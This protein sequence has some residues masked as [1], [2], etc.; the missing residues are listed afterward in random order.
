M[1][2]PPW[3][4]DDAG[5]HLVATVVL[6]EG[7]TGAFD[8]LVPETC[9]E[10]IQAGRRVRVPFGR[11]NRNVVGYCVEVETKTIGSRRLKSIQSVVDQATLLSPAMLRL[12][13]WMA[14][15]YLASWGQVLE[16]VVPMAVRAQAGTREVTF[17]RLAADALQRQAKMKLP[18]KQLEVMQ[19][20][21]RSGQPVPQSQV[22]ESVGCTTAPIQALRKKG[23]V[24]GFARRVHSFDMDD[25]QA[26]VEEDLLLNSDQRVAL[27]TIHSALQAQQH[28]TVLLHGITGSGKTEVYIQAIRE[29]IRFGRQ[30]IV[31]V[32]EISLTPQTCQ[33]FR[34]RFEH[35]AV[36]HS[37][38]SHVERHSQWARIAKGEIQVV[39]GARSAIFAPTPHLGLIILDEEH[40]SSFKQD[41]VPRYHARDVAVERAR[42]ESIPLVLGSATPSLESWFRAKAGDYQLV[43]M[44]RRILHRPLPNVQ[45][46]D[47]RV[48]AQDRFSRGAL[49]RRMCQAVNTALQENG[50]VILLLNRRGFSTH[51]QCR[52]CGEVARCPHCEVALTHHRDGERAVCHYCDYAAAAPTQCP[53]CLSTAVRFSGLGTQKLEAEVRSRFA[54]ASC[55]RMDSDAMRKHGSHEQALAKFRRGEVQILVGTQMIAKGLDFPNVTLVG[56]VNADTALHFPDFRA[57]ER[58]FQLVT[59]VAGRTGRG[60]KRGL[61]LVQTFQPDHFAIDCASRHDYVSFADEELITR[62]EL[63]YPPNAAMARLVIRGP[64]ENVAQQFSEHLSQLAEQEATNRNM[65]MDILGPTAAPLAKLRDKFRFHML[66]RGKHREE[67]R[68]VIIG[69]TPQVKPP[70]EIQ[71]TVDMDPLDML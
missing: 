48:E 44:P 17:V 69:F 19:F 2:P 56:V 11:S 61:V 71:W 33:R 31:L 12:T 57:S 64:V 21:V 63:N 42:M 46:V 60:D 15:Q 41:N 49:S 13:R 62:E 54:K 3:E 26:T 24:E 36:L 43:S 70:A 9:R 6:S 51:I 40:D 28:Q 45:T 37:H 14:D 66:L 34:S 22:A 55:L 53:S 16:T 30:A 38:M 67:L 35:V 20:L 39:V 65:I 59:Q 25:V 8:Y 52:A 58:T 1:D 10:Q 7:P 4:V 47:L 18:K 23:L 50:Q 27:D 29:V 5:H 68:Q 32:P